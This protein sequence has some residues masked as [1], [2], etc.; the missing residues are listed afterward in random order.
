MNNSVSIT[1]ERYQELIGKEM[2]LDGILKAHPEL[3]TTMKLTP[4][5][6]KYK[7]ALEE[8]VERVNQ[9]LNSDHMKDMFQIAYVHGFKYKGES[10]ALD[11]VKVKKLLNPNY[12][13]PL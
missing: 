7:V 10:L 12:I 8:F 5:A 2:H 11:I 9:V 1:E 13:S 3:E 4:T 6:K